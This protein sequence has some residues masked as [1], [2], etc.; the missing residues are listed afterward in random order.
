MQLTAS[1]KQLLQSEKGVKPDA[2]E[3]EYRKAAYGA[4][5]ADEGFEAKYLETQKSDES[6]GGAAIVSALEAINKRLESV[7]NR[8][9]PG[10]G[11]RS[12]APGLPG[13]EP[14]GDDPKGPSM[15]ERSISAGMAERI[16]SVRIKSAKERYDS[17]KR[18]MLF[19][20]RTRDN[21]SHPLAGK[22]VMDSHYAKN[23]ITPHQIHE[24]SQLDMA[25]AGAWI[26]F[27]LHQEKGGL[28]VPHQLRMTDHDWDL[29]QWMLHECEFSG[30]VHGGVIGG[31]EADGAIGLKSQKLTGMTRKA[32]LDDSTSGG[33]E[34]A[35]I[36]FDDMLITTPLL[37]SEFYPK[38][39]VVNITRGRRIEGVSMANVTLGAATE[40][41]AITLFNTANFIAAF[42]TTI[43][44]CMGSIEIGLDFLSDSPIDIAS[45]VATSY[46][47]QQL[48]WLDDQIVDGDGTT[49]PEGVLQSSGTTTVNATNGAGGPWT[50][51]DIEALLFGVSKAYKGSTDPSKIGFGSNNT[52]YRRVRG[53]AVGTTDQRR[54]F[55][56]THEDYKVFERFWGINESFGNR[57][58]AFGNW[59]RYRMYRR[60][61]ISVRSTQEGFTAVRSNTMLLTA[62]SR[63][64]G[65]LEDG[66][67]FALCIDGVS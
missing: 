7:E 56:M 32:L 63:W 20:E 42:D 22:P 47:E 19:P 41:T 15:F 28:S 5:A 43:F 65:Q 46:Q 24:P 36:F 4:L 67:A 13:N 17:T 18:A 45:A 23:G 1:L 38:V 62:R 52:T 51:G 25:A 10:K 49:E 59:Y 48:K 40:G 53:I 54:V 60:A 61:G 26:K 8:D 55:G 34:A 44:V 30:V 21:K 29:V 27:G 39:K 35:P 3:Q 64:G 66:A 6:K 31:T 14:A 50:V 11:L 2:T 12:D 16:D 37:H 9:N 57:E 58:I 33:L